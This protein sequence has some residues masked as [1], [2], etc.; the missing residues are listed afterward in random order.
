VVRALSHSPAWDFKRLFP[1]LSETGETVITAYWFP[2]QMRFFHCLELL[3][4]GLLYA[5]VLTWLFARPASRKCRLHL[6]VVRFRLERHKLNY[7][8]TQEKTCN[9]H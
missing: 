2:W 5:G 3:A 8:R 6:R 1:P 7:G 4:D 9:D